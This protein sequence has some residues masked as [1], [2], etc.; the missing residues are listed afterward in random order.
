MWLIHHMSDSSNGFKQVNARLTMLTIRLRVCT[1]P[2][3]RR[4]LLRDFRVLLERADE[5]ANAES[6]SGSSE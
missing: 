6:G 1:D 2:E 4:S 5:L 3:Q